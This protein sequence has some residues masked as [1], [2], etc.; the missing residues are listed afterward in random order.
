MQKLPLGIQTFKKV[1]EENLLYIDKTKEALELITGDGNYFFLSRPRRFG[2]SLFLD[3]LHNIFE[4]NK[5]L[6]EGLYIDDKYHFETYPVIKIDWAGDFK[7]LESTKQ[8]AHFILEQNQKRLGVAC[9]MDDSPDICFNRLI[10]G[11]YEKYQKPVVI[12]VDEYD[13]PILD[14]LENL[15][16]A[17]EN[18]DF[19]RSFYVM[20][21]SNDAYI[22]FAFLT[23]ISKFSKANIFSGLNNL[24]DISLMKKYGNICGYTHEDLQSRFSDYLSDVDLEKVKQWYNGYYFLKDKIYN[25]FDIL[26]FFYNDNIFKNYWWESGNPYFLIELVRKNS[27]FLPKLSNLKVDESLL[28]SFDVEKID[29]EVLL[30]QA[31]YL[32]IERVVEK[33]NRREYQ[34][35]VPNLEVKASLSNLCIDLLTEQKTEKFDI[36]DTVYDCLSNGDL[37]GFKE[38]LIALF[39]SIPY[40]NYV[41]NTLSHY[42]GF[43]ASVIFAYLQSLGVAIIG[44]D[45]TNKGRIDLSVFIEEKIYIIEFKVGSD[46]ALAQIKEKNYHQK[47]LNENRETYLVGINFNEDDK[48]I[49]GLKWEKIG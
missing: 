36:Q 16:S 32:T 41:K 22:K 24:T 14:N 12:L 4:G 1:R 27:Y 25:P 6:F 10:Q 19:L 20:M 30:Y 8:R 18:R 26:K 44:E 39:A 45:V 7:T 15:P 33:R 5:A 46:D 9:E 40:N 49:S 23:G 17:L 13:K 42:E 47:Y 31:G 34:L 21:K 43:Y 2:K 28:S 37:E 35:K 3:T 29:I 11:T 48:N 38:T